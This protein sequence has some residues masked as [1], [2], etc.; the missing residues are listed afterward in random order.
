MQELET[1][2]QKLNVIQTA[3]QLADAEGG[4]LYLPREWL[5]KNINKF[6]DQEISAIRLMQQSEAAAKAESAAMTAAAGAPTGG[7]EMGGGGLGGELGGA[8]AGAIPGAEVPGA[9]VGAA[10]EAGAAPP[11]EMPAAG[12]GGAELALAGAILNIA[13]KQFLLENEADIKE[14]IKSVKKLSETQKI[15]KDKPV[16]IVKKKLQ[17]NNFN[18]LFVTGELKGLIRRNN[19]VDNKGI[20]DS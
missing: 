13:G 8:E 19:N 1:T 11:E 20:L 18:Y 6:N 16:A 7:T 5:Y 10:P 3:L 14:L 12:G 4:N 17:E 2:T 15:T 9:E